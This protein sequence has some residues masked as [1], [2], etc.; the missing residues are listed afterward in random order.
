[1]KST[2]KKYLSFNALSP[3]KAWVLAIVISIIIAIA[4]V[5]ISYL[6]KDTQYADK[7]QMVIF[8]LIA[9]WWV[10]FY[11]LTRRSGAKSK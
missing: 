6:L 7:S 11:G 10:P 4:M 3:E 8:L 9:I 5:V 1:M 2:F